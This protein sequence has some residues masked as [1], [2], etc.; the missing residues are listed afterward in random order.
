MAVNHPVVIDAVI[1]AQQKLMGGWGV[2]RINHPYVA[3]MGQ[4]VSA[5]FSS[6]I[7]SK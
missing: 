7:N 6:I 3:K 2:R 4:P 1:P 5:E